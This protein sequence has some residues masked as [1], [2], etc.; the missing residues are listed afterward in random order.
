[1]VDTARAS[2]GAAQKQGGPSGAR[3][4]AADGDESKV[5][6]SIRQVEK[7]T[8]TKIV[9]PPPGIISNLME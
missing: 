4:H 7:S 9:R 6:K 1:M 2:V 8:Y 3:Q 5:G